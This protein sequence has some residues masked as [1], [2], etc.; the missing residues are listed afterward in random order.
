VTSESWRERLPSLTGNLL[1][2]REITYCDASSLLLLVSEDPHVPRYISPPPPSVEAYE[3]FIAWSHGER[4]AGKSVCFAIVPH[5]LRTAVGM[6]QV[7]SL[8]RSFF[9]AEWGFVLGSAF[10][11]TGVFEE[12]ATLVA[13]FT[14]DVLHARRLEARAATVN[15]RGNGALN[16]LGAVG[17]A[18]LRKGLERDGVYHEQLLWSVLAEEWKARPPLAHDRFSELMVKKQIQNAISQMRQRPSPPGPEGPSSGTLP[19]PF[20]I[21]GGSKPRE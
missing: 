16:K 6:F 21:A 10:W 15:E 14:F 8:D 5:G 3:G 4:A 9:T 13:D 17:E 18:I 11:S 7:R 12:A 1:D 19:Y 20:F 2:L